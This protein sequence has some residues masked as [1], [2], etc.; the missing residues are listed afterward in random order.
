MKTS[1]GKYEPERVKRIIDALAAGNTRQ[2]AYTVGGISD[3][4]F[5]TWLRRH[6]EFFE[7]VKEAEA[8]AEAAHV[9][10]IVMAS[11]SGVWTA[12]AWWLERRRPN[13]WGK[14]DRVEVTIRE[15][16]QR[17]AL[18]YGLDAD[19]LISEAERIVSERA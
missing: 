19:E 13:A 2:V 10:N 3:V 18:E 9:K 15:Q 11:N 17:L 16:A 4:T 14:V 7:A 12:S 8:K 5:A 6:L 1:G